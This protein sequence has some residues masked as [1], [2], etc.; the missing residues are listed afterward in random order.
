MASPKFLEEASKQVRPTYAYGLFFVS[1]NYI[2]YYLVFHYY[3]PLEYYSTIAKDEKLFNDEIAR[4][5]ANMQGFLDRERIIVNNIRVRPRVVMIDLGF[6]ES[7]RRPYIVF[8]IR[9]RAS[10]KMGRNI[11]ENFYDSEVAEYDYAVYWVFPPGSRIIEVDMGSGNEE[12]DVVGG[13]V[14]AIYGYK[15]RRTGGYEKIVFE[16]SKAA[17]R[18]EEYKNDSN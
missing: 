12:W 2:A 10:V 16:V 3:D 17:I 4:L 1:L 11:Y 14:L 18:E 5:W 6:T 15:G 9:F 8:T 7:K 13:N